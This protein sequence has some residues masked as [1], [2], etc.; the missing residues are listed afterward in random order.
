MVAMNSGLFCLTMSLSS[1]VKL[2]LLRLFILNWVKMD[3]DLQLK[4]MDAADYGKMKVAE[5]R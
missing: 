5:S 4:V 1:T 2:S 3:Q